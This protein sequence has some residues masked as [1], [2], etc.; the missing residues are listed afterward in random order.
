[1]HRR[2]SWMPPQATW[3]RR[4][5]H[6]VVREPAGPLEPLMVRTLREAGRLVVLG[7]FGSGK[8]EVSRRVGAA[9][10]VPV[11]PLRVVA[12]APDPDATL[13][14]LLG[15]AEV[16]ILDGLDEIGRPH[17]A[18]VAE[19]VERVTAPL[20]GWVLTSRPGHVRTDLGEPDPTQLDAFH[21]PLVEIAPYPVPAEAPAVCADNPV[22]LSLWLQGA[23][24][25]TPRAI[26]EAWLGA[27]G[28]VDALEE[29]A[30]RSFRDPGR[31]HEGGSFRAGDVA[32]LPPRLFVEDLDGWRRFGH[33][34]LYDALV[35]RRLGRRLAEAQG[36]GPDDLTGVALSGAMRAFLVGPF[37]GWAHDAAWV[38][39]PRGNFVSG[40]ARSSDERPLVVRHLPAP[41]RVARRPV[42]D[43]EFARFLAATGP[44]PPWLELLAHW[45]DG[46]PV[47]G[48]GDH[49][50]HHLRPED[51]EAYA[52]WAGA[53]LPAA[54][55]WEKAARGWDGRNY[56]W[57]D[58]FDPARANTAESGR[59]R[60][61][62]VEAH[63]QGS[64]LYA[65]IGDVFEYTASP[66]R[67]RPDR[68]R[69]VMGG[70]YAHTA[71][72]ASLRLSH[73]LSGRLKCGLRLAAPGEDR[74]PAARRS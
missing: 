14:T 29:L 49:P 48:T 51:A 50:V 31:S 4:D 71:L 24:G 34:S 26:A 60:T 17:A 45:R 20:R 41:V 35:A 70:S 16:A 9:M 2:M 58:A 8:T 44:R 39:V 19:L 28:V 72:R 67:D 65:M 59:E 57:G 6:Q 22:L 66:Y 47:P 11:V 30:W 40:G 5:R 42:T 46:A 73:T 69:V 18:G 1:M 15:T 10:G 33:R 37:P 12:R 13:R 61:A 21:L 64:G 36:Q 55:A 74:A 63:P 68:G 32:G 54:D 56:P 52:A 25:D 3:L 7:A 23:R 43:A 53:A 38:H 62:P 27:T